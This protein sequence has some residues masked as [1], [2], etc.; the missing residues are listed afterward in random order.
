MRGTHAPSE[1][2]IR[3][4]LRQLSDYLE[5]W[6]AWS[7][8]HMDSEDGR[9]ARV[10]SASA[11]SAALDEPLGVGERVTEVFGAPPLLPLRVTWTCVLAEP[12]ARLEFQ[13]EDG[14]D[15]IARNC[16][17]RFR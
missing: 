13:S 2:R 16:C 6:T 5:Q 11:G 3:T 7:F 14:L 17:M 9:R 4:T 1:H 8:Q 10:E 12:P 15:G